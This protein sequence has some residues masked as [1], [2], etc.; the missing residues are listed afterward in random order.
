MIWHRLFKEIEM[1][2]M[3]IDVP[4][5][6]EEYKFDI[7]RFVSQMVYKLYVHRDKTGWEHLEIDDVWYLLLDEVDE[8]REALKSNNINDIKNELADVANYCMILH[9]VLRRKQPDLF[10]DQ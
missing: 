6:I 9:S 2:T 4:I 7:E 5:D 8:V 3:Q 10:D 1:T